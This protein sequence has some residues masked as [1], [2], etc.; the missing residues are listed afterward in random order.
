MIDEV[1]YSVRQ[2]CQ[3]S[4][5]SLLRP[6]GTKGA[7]PVQE[8]KFQRLSKRQHKNKGLVALVIMPM[9]RRIYMFL[10]FG[11]SCNSTSDGWK[12]AMATALTCAIPRP[13]SKVMCACRS[14]TWKM[15]ITG[16]LPPTYV[17]KS[18]I[19]CI[20][21]VQLMTARVQVAICS[22]Y[23]YHAGTSTQFCMHWTLWYARYF[24][25][26]GWDCPLCGYENS[27]LPGTFTYTRG[28]MKEK[29]W[30]VI[31]QS[32]GNLSHVCCR[33]VRRKS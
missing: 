33:L 10:Q 26:G 30:A 29:L 19:M 11:A 17:S 6:H 7:Q 28:H 8:T 16:H 15:W 1:C 3:N 5:G 18:K 23:W 13:F 20:L 4:G 22:E 2:L 9:S 32:P 27:P 24:W 25:W 31:T 21:G 12:E 14:S